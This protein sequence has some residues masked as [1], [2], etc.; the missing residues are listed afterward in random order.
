[1]KELLILLEKI[2]NEKEQRENN[3]NYEYT[4][5]D[6]L[7]L[8]KW[9]D[10]GEITLYDLTTREYIL[11]G[12]S[13]FQKNRQERHTLCYRFPND[14]ARKKWIEK[15]SKQDNNIS[16]RLLVQYLDD[17]IKKYGENEIDKEA[18]LRWKKKRQTK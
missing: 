2:K 18:Y 12:I 14:L 3:N 8:R 5:E 11:L 13:L 17:S 1:M 6:L 15:Y 4:E 9:L 10:L 7:T 16:P